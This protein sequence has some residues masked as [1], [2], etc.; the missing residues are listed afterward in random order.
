M[1]MRFTSQKTRT[2][3]II[4][5]MEIDEKEFKKMILSYLELLLKNWEEYFTNLFEKCVLEGYDVD[6]VK[7]FVDGKLYKIKNEKDFV[8]TVKELFGPLDTKL[9]EMMKKE[10]Q[11]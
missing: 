3:Y 7:I 11:I 2:G 1:K 10:M 6:Y 4:H 8:K 5:T 9:L